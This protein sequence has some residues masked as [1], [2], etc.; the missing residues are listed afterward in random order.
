ME[1][2]QRLIGQRYG[3]MRRVGSGGMADVYLAE[4]RRLGRR[5]AVKVLHPAE[6]RDPTAVARFRREAMAAAALDH[7]GIVPIFDWGESD[8]TYFIVMAYVPGEDLKA[9]LGRRGPLPETEALG[10]ARQVAGALAAAH[11][12]GIV[13]R[14][15]KPHNILL[16]PDGQARVTD[17]GIARALDQAPPEG[18]L[19]LGTALYLAPEQAR[20]EAVD[21]RAD[22][23]SLGVVL[24]ELLTGRTPFTGDSLPALARQ[25]LARTPAAPSA[26]RPGL[27]R[28]TDDVVLRALAKEPEQ[29]YQSA[30][31]LDAALDAALS[32][33]AG[34]GRGSAA[35]HV[36]LLRL[37]PGDLAAARPLA[38]YPAQARVAVRPLPRPPGDWSLTLGLVV[39]LLAGLA[40]VVMVQAARSGGDVAAGG[41]AAA[42]ASPSPASGIAVVAATPT[43]RV[44]PTPAAAQTPT[45]RPTSTALPSP[46]AAEVQPTPTPKPKPPTPTPTPT[47]PRPTPTPTPRRAPTPTPTPIPTPTP[48]AK[49]P[50]S[51]WF[52]RVVDGP[53]TVVARFYL[54]LNQH[55]YDQAAALWDDRMRA[56]YPPD[57]N[58]DGRFADTS[59]IWVQ[60]DSQQSNNGRRAVVAVELLERKQSGENIRWVGTWT[61]VKTE[62]GW[63]L[64][65]PDLRQG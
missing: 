33:L 54:L 47:P 59:W 1:R 56:A 30:A 25:H 15:I 49:A 23:Y 8:D 39:F 42:I 31:E 43:P 65:E 38:R 55:K 53:T 21:A 12:H 45:P 7:R 62:G 58:V 22:V 29:R 41:A 2:D 57:V 36:P 32:A 3:L 51:G 35:V 6:A 14:D 27:T 4:D 60:R 19:V 52:E 48:E 9:A 40:G 18:G 37:T 44:A 28:T 26:L 64:D 63:L 24:F 13:H 17:F 34:A 20:G 10:I 46:E 50:I 5:V 11:A 61:L 16:Q